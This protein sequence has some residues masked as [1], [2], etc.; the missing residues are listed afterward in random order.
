MVRGGWFVS[1]AVIAVLLLVVRLVLGRPLLPTHARPLPV[2]DAVLVAASLV[3]LVFHCAAMFAPDAVGA[4]RVLDGPARVVRDL[5]DPIGQAAY[6]A[7]AGALV[8]GARR[9]WW[10][11]PVSAALCLVAVGWTMYGGFTVTQHLVA[12]VAAGVVIAGVMSALVTRLVPGSE[13]PV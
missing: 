4:L 5:R 8:V 2:A 13:A 9:L 10:P 6:W 11:A 12:I 1:L 7:P 3:L